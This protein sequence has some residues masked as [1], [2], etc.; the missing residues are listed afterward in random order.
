[1]TI[2]RCNVT[3]DGLRY[4][5]TGEL[6]HGA[7]YCGFI[8]GEE[9]TNL[10]IKNCLLAPHFA[11]ST[12]SKIPGKMVRMG[13]YALSLTS[14]INARFENLKQTKDITDSNYWGLMGSNY[15][16]NVELVDCVISRFDA[17]CGVTNGSKRLTPV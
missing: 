5:V 2:T 8:T 9:C 15:C 4:E 6:D 11:Y 16:K 13:S 1:M 7:P 12:E 17:H 3:V 14:V 10:V